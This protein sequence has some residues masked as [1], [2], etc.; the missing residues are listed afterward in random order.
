MNPNHKHWKGNRWNVQVEW[1]NGEI[2][3][4]PLSILKKSDPISCAIY[5]KENDLL[6]LQGWKAFKKLARKQKK[7]L[8]L[9]NQAKLQSY[10]NAPM[11][12][13]GIQVPRNHEQAMEIDKQNGNTL[14]YDAEQI[15]LKSIDDY[16]T[17]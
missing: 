13:Y 7:L 8:R 14:W 17:F 11:Y 12:K 16:G 1:E 9:V 4:E 15:E 6:E 10:R 3:W 5:A 2:T